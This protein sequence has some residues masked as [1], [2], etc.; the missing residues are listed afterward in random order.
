MDN[1]N[2]LQYLNELVVESKIIEDVP[3]NVSLI[4]KN[5]TA[6]VGNE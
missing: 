4:E 3:I 2:L 1:D 6:V 5:I